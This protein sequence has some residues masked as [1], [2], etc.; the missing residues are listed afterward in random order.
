MYPCV[1]F[2]LDDSDSFQGLSM[3]MYVSSSVKACNKH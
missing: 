1:R 2:L 3:M